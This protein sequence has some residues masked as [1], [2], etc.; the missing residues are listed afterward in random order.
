MS[1]SSLPPPP[2]DSRRWVIAGAGVLMQ[3]ALGA[4]YAWSVFRNP[5]MVRFHWTIAQVTL[6]PT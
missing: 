3:A 5:L 1:Y 6:T 4:I 2:P